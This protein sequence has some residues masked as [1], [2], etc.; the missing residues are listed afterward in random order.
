MCTHINNV[1]ENENCK[2]TGFIQFLLLNPPK[3]ALFISA[4]SASPLK[5]FWFKERERLVEINLCGNQHY[6][7]H[8]VDCT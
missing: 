3:L 6:V 4:P 5:P 2:I 8:A 1:A 7:T